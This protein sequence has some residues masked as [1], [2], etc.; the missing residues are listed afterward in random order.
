VAASAS[1]AVAAAHR[2]RVQM[3]VQQLG[4][5]MEPLLAAG[6]VGGGGAIREGAAA[7]WGRLAGARAQVPAGSDASEAATA[8]FA[9][10]GLRAR[11]VGGFDG[12]KKFERYS[13]DADVTGW[14]TESF[15]RY[16]GL[17]KI[18]LSYCDKLTDGGIGELAR[19]CTGLTTVNLSR[20]Y[21][22]TDGGLCELARHCAGLT[23]VNLS[24][25]NK[26]TDGGLGDFKRQLP[27]CEVKLSVFD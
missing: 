24:H 8:A 5:A 23:T 13:T 12:A 21:E 1:E 7:A 2:W 14:L 26:L 4:A 18:D 25:C 6:G 3:L 10:L 22:L 11:A 27:N 20:C 19:H 15:W 9:A 16:V 17:T